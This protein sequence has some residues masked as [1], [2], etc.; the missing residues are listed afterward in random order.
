MNFYPLDLKHFG[1]SI[2]Y[3]PLYGMLVFP[4]PVCGECTHRSSQCEVFCK[5]SVLDPAARNN[6]RKLNCFAEQMEFCHEVW[7]RGKR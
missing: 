6:T 4:F 2:L 1:I 3:Y 7:R 5:L